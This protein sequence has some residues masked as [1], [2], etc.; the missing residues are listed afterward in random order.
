V[1]VCIPFHVSSLTPSSE[2]VRVRL[3]IG[4]GDT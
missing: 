1:F 4:N 2:P 3:L